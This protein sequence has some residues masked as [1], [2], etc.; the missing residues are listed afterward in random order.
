MHLIPTKKGQGFAYTH[1]KKACGHITTSF[2]DRPFTRSFINSPV[3]VAKH[4]LFNNHAVFLLTTIAI[5]QLLC[6]IECA[7]LKLTNVNIPAPEAAAASGDT[8]NR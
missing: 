8:A 2:Y 6:S 5:V 1:L 7:S 3:C 4:R